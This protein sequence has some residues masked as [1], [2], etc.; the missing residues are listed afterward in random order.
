MV[1]YSLFIFLFPVGCRN[2]G[3]TSI[4]FRG[5]LL[6]CSCLLPYV[7]EE[8]SAQCQSIRTFTLIRIDKGSE[9][10]V[11]VRQIV[12]GSYGI[13]FVIF[14]LFFLYGC[15]QKFSVFCY[16]QMCSAQ[17]FTVQRSYDFHQSFY[18][19]TFHRQY[20]ER[21]FKRKY[22]ENSIDCDITLWKYVAQTAHIHDSNIG[23]M[24]QYTLCRES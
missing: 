2:N 5:N 20:A 19:R 22:F 21:I 9:S 14:D 7:V 23:R 17:S 6:A 4:Q 8:Q 11:S 18:F 12:N 15:F 16:F 24:L 1:I 10:V 13:V 3:D